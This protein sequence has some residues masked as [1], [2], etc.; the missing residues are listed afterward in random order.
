M[1]CMWEL[2]SETMNIQFT[3]RDL[4]LM[5][6]KLLIAKVMDG[7]TR[8]I[9]NGVGSLTAVIFQGVFFPLYYYFFVRVFINYFCCWH[10]ILTLLFTLFSVIRV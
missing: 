6:M 10:G 4:A 9:S 5:L 8:S 3:S 2:G 7:V 1:I